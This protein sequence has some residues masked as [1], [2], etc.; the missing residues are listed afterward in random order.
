MASASESAARAAPAGE[1]SAS[2]EQLEELKSQIMADI[3]AKLSQKE[4]SLWRRGQVEI[5]RLQLEQAQVATSV[6]T[7]QE[8][9]EAIVKEN[10]KI[11]GALIH[12]TLKFE[13]VVR[14]MREVLR[15]VQVRPGGGADAEG[16]CPTPSAA[17]EASEAERQEEQPSAVELQVEHQTPGLS[18]PFSGQAALGELWSSCEKSRRRPEA[19]TPV[20][21]WHPQRGCD[22]GISGLDGYLWDAEDV[23]GDRD[24]KTF[25]TP[26]RASPA[27]ASC[28]EDLIGA[29]PPPASWRGLTPTVASPAVL[30]L[31]SALPSG[32]TGAQ[33]SPAMLNVSTGS[34]STA[35]STPGLGLKRLHLAECLKTKADAAGLAAG[36]AASALATPQPAAKAAGGQGQLSAGS[37]ATPATASPARNF[38]FLAVELHKEPDCATLGVEVKEVESSLRVEVIDADGL[39]GRHNLR[40]ESDGNRVLP[41][42]RI[43]EVNGVRHEPASMLLECKARQRI[44]FVIVRDVAVAAQPATCVSIDE[45]SA[46]VGAEAAAGAPA[47][48]AGAGDRGAGGSPQPTRLRPEATAFVPSSAQKENGAP[49][50]PPGLEKHGT[51]AQAAAAAAEGQGEAVCRALF[52]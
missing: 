38:D 27:R 33:P 5:R 12:L 42:D 14:E 47:G 44:S 4:E 25:C 23:L 36:G 18:T 29:P 20:P 39:V 45:D 22:S 32:S 7:L 40:Q 31:A 30:S 35:A 52:R 48:D 24:P 11:R 16:L 17:S 3:E 26:P 6:G 49:P 50:G 28:L 43:I 2:P 41:G 46:S 13:T 8:R 9:Q 21:M 51:A 34:C 19:Q 1:V 37:L 15:A 10:Q